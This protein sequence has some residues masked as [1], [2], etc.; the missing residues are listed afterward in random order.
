MVYGDDGQQED[1]GSEAD[2]EAEVTAIPS[3]A[4]MRDQLKGLALSRSRSIRVL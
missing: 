2:F 3:L 1:A 4:D